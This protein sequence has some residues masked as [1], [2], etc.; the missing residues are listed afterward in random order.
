MTDYSFMKTGFDM[1]GND[2]YENQKNIVALVTLFGTNA[3]RTSFIYIKHAKRGGVTVEDIKRAVMLETFFFMKRPD[4]MEKA[5]EIKNE[6]FNSSEEDSEDEED[7]EGAEGEENEEIIEVFVESECSCA[8]C[9]CIN[10]IY[11]R[12]AAWTPQTPMEKIL[13]KSVENFGSVPLQST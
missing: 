4:V 3:I 5:N 8:L 12:W 1:V 7:V 10:K 13:K 6:L 11:E 9:S 2:E